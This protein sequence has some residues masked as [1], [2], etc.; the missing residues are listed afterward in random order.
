[1]KTSVS[2]IKRAEHGV[3]NATQKG[4]RAAKQAAFSPLVEF[5]ARMGFA[6]RGLVY[7]MMGVMAIQVAEGGRSAPGDQQGALAMIGAQPTGHIVLIFVLIGL[8]G[9]SLWGVIRSLFD[10]LHLGSD[11]KGLVQRGWSLISAAMY[12]SLIGP[13]WSSITSAGKAAQNGAQ[14]AQTQQAVTML[15]YRPWG[16]LT[17]GAVGLFIIIAGLAQIYQGLSRRFDKQFTPYDLNHAQMVWIKRLGRIGT[18]ARGF[19]F[20]LTGV[21][22]ALSAYQANPKKAVGIDGALLALVRQPYG[23]WLLGIVAVGLMAF[24]VYSI[25]GAAWFRM[26]RPSQ[27]STRR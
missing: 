13:T 17:V 21:F 2:D 25:T 19:V 9:Y 23:P 20:G 14:T 1:M 24:G 16:R 12:A 27:Q 10:P 26:R 5:L 15:L 7:L 8:V 4:E 6:A 11:L 22:V 18:V 3:E